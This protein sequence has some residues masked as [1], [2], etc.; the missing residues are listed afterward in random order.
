MLLLDEEKHNFITMIKDFAIITTMILKMNIVK[1][2]DKYQKMKN[3][4]LLLT[5]VKNYF[6]AIKEACKEN[7]SEFEEETNIH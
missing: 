2:S 3:L 5:F 4:T 7:A 1:L 6:K